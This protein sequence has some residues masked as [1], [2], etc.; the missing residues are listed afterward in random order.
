MLK[1]NFTEGGLFQLS[2]QSSLRELC[3]SVTWE[4]LHLSVLE[5]IIWICKL[6][7]L[8]FSEKRR[9]RKRDMQVP[10]FSIDFNSSS[11]L[12]K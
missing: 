12:L 8:R 1:G 7:L 11:F 4:I 3:P 9:E 6:S 10:I 5:H 2:H